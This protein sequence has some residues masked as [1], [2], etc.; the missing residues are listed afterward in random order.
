M[1]VRIPVAIEREEDRRELCA[2]LTACGLDVRVARIKT[3]NRGTPKRYVE[4][5][6]SGMA[7]PML[8]TQGDVTDAEI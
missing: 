2:I 6:D 7:E 5:Q 1:W 3:T 4:Y 8:I